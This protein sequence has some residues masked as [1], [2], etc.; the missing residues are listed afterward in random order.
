[1]TTLKHLQRTDSQQH[2]RDA[3]TALATGL[4]HHTA[5]RSLGAEDRGRTSIPRHADD[6]SAGSE[7]AIDR[8]ISYPSPSSVGQQLLT[9]PPPAT[10]PAYRTNALTLRFAPVQLMARAFPKLLRIHMTPSKHLA[11]LLGGGHHQKRQSEADRRRDTHSRLHR[12]M[13][14]R[15]PIAG[16]RRCTAG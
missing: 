10:S 9:A 13:G 11:R 6:T 5:G 7:R 8:H 15:T 2:L 12:D 14:A 16:R 1:V 3:R 4:P